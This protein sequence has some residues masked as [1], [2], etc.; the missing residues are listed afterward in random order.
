MI[1]HVAIWIFHAM[2]LVRIW[3]SKPHLVT[4][5]TSKVHFF[6]TISYSTNNSTVQIISLTFLR[7]SIDRDSLSQRQTI[8]IKGALMVHCLLVNGFLV[9]D[10]PLEMTR[11]GHHHLRFLHL[12]VNWAVWIFFVSSWAHTSYLLLC[13]IKWIL[14]VC[15]TIS[16]VE[17]W[18][19][20]WLTTRILNIR[21]RV[22]WSEN[23]N[24][25]NGYAFI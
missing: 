7:T 3:R 23:I 12:L 15:K 2:S 19:L 11:L 4:P 1:E 21:T 20:C 14:W 18:G 9:F 17:M 6:V 22:V 16:L 10:S 8:H 5:W 25:K 13:W 24:K